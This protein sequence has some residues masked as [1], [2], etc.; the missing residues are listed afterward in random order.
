LAWKSPIARSLHLL[1][2]AQY[3]YIED[4]TFQ[5]VEI[6]GVYV[7]PKEADTLYIGVAQR[8]SILV[9]TK[10][11]TDENFAIV[12]VADSVLFDSIPSDLQ[13]NNT[14]WLE[15][16]SSA[17]HPQANIQVSEAQDLV[18]FDDL[19]LVPTDGMP[20]LPEAGLKINVAVVMQNLDNGYNYALLNNITYTAPKVPTLYTVL[21]SGDLVTNAKIYGEFT[22]PMILNHNDVVE[23]VLN[24]N[25]TGSHPF[26]LHGHNFQV[27]DRQPP[28]GANFYDYADLDEPVPY[29]PSNH[30]AFPPVPARRDVV[31]VPPQ[32]YFVMRFVADNPGVWLFHCH[33]DWH[34]AA[35]LAMVLIEAPTQLQQSLKVP[36]DHWD[37]C[38]AGDIAFEGNAAGNTKD[39]LDLGGQNAQVGFLPGGF[40][41]RGI[42]ALVFSCISAFI[43][44]AAISIYGLSDLKYHRRNLAAE[45]STSPIQTSIAQPKTDEVGG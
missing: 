8:Y 11:T 16:N 28:L 30:T 3:F 23:I 19:T 41:A 10:N 22:H 31:V 27:I 42:V 13:L 44:M 2:T 39:Y 20:L 5:I 17:P 37:A 18:P 21:S 38:K 29:D 45:T 35:G 43:G 4:H 40:T 33:I 24:N 36:D 1:S 25:D 6:D 7:E 26:H 15:Y 34:L 12:T 9:T 32:G 14:N